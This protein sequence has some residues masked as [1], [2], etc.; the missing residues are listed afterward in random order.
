MVLTNGKTI[1]NNLVKS[2]E[3]LKYLALNVM[4]TKTGEAVM[5]EGLNKVADSLSHFGLEQFKPKI[6]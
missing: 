1:S 6:S 4:V 5:R 2:G 3:N